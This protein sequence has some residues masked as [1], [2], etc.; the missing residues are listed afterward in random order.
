MYFNESPSPDIFTRVLSHLVILF[1]LPFFLTL[2]HHC[3]L[4]FSFIIYPA[5]KSWSN[6]LRLAFSCVIPS[7][8]FTLLL[9]QEYCGPLYCC[10]FT[11]CLLWSCSSYLC[12]LS[13]TQ[14][15][16]HAF[17]L[18]HPYLPL[19]PNLLSLVSCFLLLFLTPADIPISTVNMAA[20]L[21]LVHHFVFLQIVDGGGGYGILPIFFIC[22]TFISQGQ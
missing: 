4:H 2:F 15:D 6:L 22:Q 19:T 7:P 5:T 17:S 13:H 18:F 11:Y 8:A 9:P 12:I 20:I 3:C 1:D 16:T 10:C 14:T 21:C